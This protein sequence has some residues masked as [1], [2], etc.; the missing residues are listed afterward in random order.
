MHLSAF[1][2]CSV[3]QQMEIIEMMRDELGPI[4]SRCGGV[5]G[6]GGCGDAANPFN[7]CGK[8][9]GA[10]SCDDARYSVRIVH[11][12]I[13]NFMAKSFKFSSS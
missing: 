12:L 5:G 3:K 10:D 8:L 2:H 6:M 9:G 7:A 13:V 4:F 1:S 11:F